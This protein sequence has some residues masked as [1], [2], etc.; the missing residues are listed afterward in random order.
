MVRAVAF[1]RISRIRPPETAMAFSHRID[2]CRT[3]K[4]IRTNRRPPA[5]W[6][7]KG[8]RVQPGDRAGAPAVA[9]DDMMTLED[10]PTGRDMRIT[11]ISMDERHTLRM[12]ELGIRVGGVTRVTQ[13][14][15]FGGRV[16]AIGTGRIAID[17]AT[18]RAI[19][20]RPVCLA[21]M[22][23]MTHTNGAVQTTQATQITQAARTVRGDDEH[24]GGEES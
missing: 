1:H 3:V 5:Q 4:E 16:L 23:Q 15:N 12:L 2:Y 13:R 22:A 10:C 6:A 11:G 19:S 18:A 8:M 20:V 14:S 7:G 9:Q 17:G 24:E 21:P